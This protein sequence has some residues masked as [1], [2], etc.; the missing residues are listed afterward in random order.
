MTDI[1][2]K[3]GD[4][5]LVD[6]SNAIGHQQGGTRYAVIVSN[7]L[8]NRVSP[9]VEIL[10][11]TSQRDNSTLPTHAHFEAGEI[12]GL[13]K[14]TTFEA[15]SKWTINKFQI[16]KFVTHLSDSQ[17]ERIATAMLFATPV[18]IKAVRS[19]VHQSKYFEKI[20]NYS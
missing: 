12:Q 16:I 8:G 4:V 18:V 7:N 10:P 9:T 13:P 14:G 15:E 19:G 5:L 17:M 2:V 3:T 1:N 6:L 11:G 20:L